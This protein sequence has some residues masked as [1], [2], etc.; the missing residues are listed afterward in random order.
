MGTKTRFGNIK[1]NE[2]SQNNKFSFVMP[3]YFRSIV[4]ALVTAAFDNDSDVRVSVSKS[5]H[6][7]G[8]NHTT[9]VVRACM[10]F[11]RGHKKVKKK[12]IAQKMINH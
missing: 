9:I 8:L 7:I 12:K 2:V 10:E 4:Q 3:N 11:I 1:Q 5:L 6:K